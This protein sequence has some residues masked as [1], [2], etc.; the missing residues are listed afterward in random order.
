MSQQKVFVLGVGVSP[1][2]KPSKTNDYPEMAQN[3]GQR[4]L[5]DARI[6]FSE[7]QAAIVGYCYGEATSG[8]RAVYGLGV[9][10]IPILNVNNNCSTGSTALFTAKKMV[11]SGAYD[12]VLAL[13]FEKMEPGNLSVKFTDRTHPADRHFTR[14]K[15]VYTGD[16]QPCTVSS[17]A[18]S[19]S[20]ASSSFPRTIPATPPGL[21]A[22][23]ADVCHLFNFA[24]RDHMDMYGTTVEQMAKVAYKNHKHSINNP[25]A[26][27][28]AEFPYERIL[29]SALQLGGPHTKL[30]S[31]PIADGAAAA[32][33]VSERYIQQHAAYIQHEYLVQLLSCQMVTDLPST[34]ESS[35]CISIS[36]YDMNKTA[37]QKAYLESGVTPLDVDVIELHDC[38][39][40]NE[41]FQ[42]EALGLCEP[43][44]SGQLID[45]LQW[46]QNH[47]G[48]ELGVIGDRW[49]VNPSG[50]L[51]SKGHPIGAT[52]LA[53]CAE[54]NWQLRGE[55]GRRQVDNAKVALQQNFGIGGAAVVS[56]YKKVK[57]Q[58]ILQTSVKSSL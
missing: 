20:S 12:C 6:Q 18:S 26:L 13:G 57:K 9:S 37:A 58:D 5:Q 8:Q 10:G 33:L 21:N 7:V 52:G 25:Y 48:A 15:S 34:F 54:L 11:E 28:Q 36:G 24:G 16:V 19:S 4:A 35:S 30:M 17:T 50:G 46:K 2:K 22:F 47:A 53:Q 29:K 56:I 31:C 3:A 44:K 14:M 39:A 27:V 41:L 55:A 49:V 1:F 51:L 32:I 42:Y 23:T 43:G 40:V 38:F 45:S